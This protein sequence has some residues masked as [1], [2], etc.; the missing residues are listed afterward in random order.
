MSKWSRKDV[1][2]KCWLNDM[3]HS[4]NIV[5]LNPKACRSTAGENLEHRKPSHVNISSTDEM[6]KTL[7][8]I[9][10]AWRVNMSGNHSTGY[11]RFIN[12]MHGK[13]FLGVI[14]KPGLLFNCDMKIWRNP[15]PYVLCVTFFWL[16]G[17]GFLFLRCSNFKTGDARLL[18]KY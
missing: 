6:V 12:I 18:A 15:M 17:W 5:K 7:Q 14:N 3:K 16:G 1:F 8:H 13:E 9:H 10:L 4:A 11:S 2:E